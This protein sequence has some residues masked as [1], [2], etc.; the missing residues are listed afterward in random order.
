MTGPGNNSDEE[1]GFAPS[2]DSSDDTGNDIGEHK[3]EYAFSNYTPR[4]SPPPDWAEPQPQPQSQPQA[5][6]QPQSPP[7]DRSQEQD[8]EGASPVIIVAVSVLVVV[9]MFAL[10]WAGVRFL[11]SGDSNEISQGPDH[12]ETT[13]T[14]STG[15]DGESRS[16]SSPDTSP[17]TSPETVTETMTTSVPAANSDLSR[18]GF[19]GGTRCPNN[20]E[21]IFVVESTDSDTRGAICET[22]SGELTYIGW[23]RQA[24]TSDPLP[25]QRNDGDSN[26]TGFGGGSHQY[27]L[28]ENKILVFEDGV[29]ITDKYA[30]VVGP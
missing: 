2:G 20:G 29:M 13:G 7:P 24:G 11:G 17:G 15:T 9:V 14:D 4:N 5:Q 1:W 8:R 23:S 25:A 26:F 12:S 3:Q 30:R 6:P 18:Y 16:G 28:S 19:A 27:N 10:G 21:I 22:R